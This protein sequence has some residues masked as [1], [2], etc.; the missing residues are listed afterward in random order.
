MQ[1]SPQCGGGGPSGEQ[2]GGVLSGASSESCNCSDPIE[3]YPKCD[4]HG[5]TGIHCPFH[6]GIAY[7][8]VGEYQ[9]LVLLVCEPMELGRCALHRY[10]RR[11][12][13]V[14]L[15]LANAFPLGTEDGW[16]AAI[17]GPAIDDRF[18]YATEPTA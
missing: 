3:Q 4:P 6:E 18:V 16:D 7:Q 15:T 10:V 17:F 8:V 11:T 9:P 5:E 12:S 2:S 1:I 13:E 14:E